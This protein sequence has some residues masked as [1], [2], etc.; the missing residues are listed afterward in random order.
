MMHLGSFEGMARGGCLVE[1]DFCS[2]RRRT[3]AFRSDRRIIGA[4][5]LALIAPAL[6]PVSTFWRSVLPFFGVPRLSDAAPIHSPATAYP[7]RVRGA[8]LILG[9]TV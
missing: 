3:V 2:A 7:R 1:I 9:A 4:I 5:L 6:L 8:L